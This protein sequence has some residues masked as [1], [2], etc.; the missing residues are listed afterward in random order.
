LT[1]YNSWGWGDERRGTRVSSAVSNGVRRC[2]LQSENRH[3]L[4]SASPKGGLLW[5]LAKSLYCICTDGTGSKGE[6][7]SSIPSTEKNKT[8]QQL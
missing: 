5:Q 2:S 1:L 8:T 3:S 6:I 4:P 7:L